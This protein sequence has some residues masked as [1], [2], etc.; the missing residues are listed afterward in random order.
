VISSS[1]RPLPDNTQQSKQTNIHAPRRAE[2]FYLPLKNRRLRPS[3]NLRN[4]VPKA[5]TEAAEKFMA[6]RLA[7]LLSF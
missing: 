6:P 7:F 5:S 1:Q 2:D 4:W 3:L